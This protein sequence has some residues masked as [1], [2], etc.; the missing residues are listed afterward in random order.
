MISQTPIPFFINPSST[1]LPIWAWVSCTDV[2]LCFCPLDHLCLDPFLFS[3]VNPAYAFRYISG[4]MHQGTSSSL[5]LL[6]L[7]L[8]VSQGTAL[9]WVC[10]WWKVLWRQRPNPDGL[11]RVPNILPG[12]ER[13]FGRGQSG[14]E[15][16]KK[17]R[18]QR[19]KR[20][21]KGWIKVGSGGS[22]LPEKDW[23][24]LRRSEADRMM[25]DIVG[26]THIPGSGSFEI[27][28][29]HSIIIFH[30]ESCCP[31]GILLMV[32]NLSLYFPWGLNRLP[33]SGSV[34]QGPSQDHKLDL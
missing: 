9:I 12:K 16:W 13:V 34:G 25:G 18:D 22:E 31:H 4:V 32:P 8:W 1:L 17:W 26:M 20:D 23:T 2:V 28:W 10:A 5:G 7:P 24:R 29:F 11:S 27:F 21:M 14:K 30:K 6:S 3:L 19:V 15:R 33:S